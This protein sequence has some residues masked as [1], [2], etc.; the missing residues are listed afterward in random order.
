MHIV[1]IRHHDKNIITVYFDAKNIKITESYT[2]TDPICML[3]TLN[4]IRE[5]AQRF[6]IQYKRTNASWIRAWKA[7]NMLYKAGMKQE[8]TG[9]VDL[10]EDESWFKRLGYWFLSLFYKY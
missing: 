5:E 4:L 7:H 1:D 9:C 3:D 10:N 8:K 6:N 2:M